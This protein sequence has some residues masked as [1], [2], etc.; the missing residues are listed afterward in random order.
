MVIK[1]FY[2]VYNEWGKLI[3]LNVDRFPEMN[4]SLAEN[5]ISDFNLN[6]S[7]SG[8]DGVYKYKSVDIDSGKLLVYLDQ[9]INLYSIFFV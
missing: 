7:G 6:I 2:A 8:Y 1:Y 3:D 4:Y 5:L 9:S